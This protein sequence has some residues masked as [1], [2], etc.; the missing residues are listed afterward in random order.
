MKILFEKSENNI[1]ASKILNDEELF[2][3]SIHCSY[4]STVQLMRHILFNICNEDE[5]IFDNKLEVKNIGSHNFLITIFT[6]KLSTKG[7]KT[8]DF[9][10]SMRDLKNLRKEADYSGQTHLRLIF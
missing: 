4:Y 3:S 2:A 8:Q 9:S 6:K 1:Y 5:K 10:K 7:L